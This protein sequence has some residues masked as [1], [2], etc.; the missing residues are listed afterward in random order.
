MCGVKEKPWVSL[1]MV[2]LRPGSVCGVGAGDVAPAAGR[3]QQELC[4]EGLSC[5]R[6]PDG[7][8]DTRSAKGLL[9]GTPP[10]S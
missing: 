5:P 1:L 4:G 7:A 8:G 2:T 9:T 10:P 3:G 6:T